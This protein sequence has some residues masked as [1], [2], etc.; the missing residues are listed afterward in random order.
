M[1]VHTK[2]SLRSGN[3]SLSAPIKY[4]CCIL[5]TRNK[6]TAD[7]LGQRAGRWDHRGAGS[8]PRFL[9]FFVLHGFAFF[10]FAG[11]GCFGFAWVCL[12]FAL[13]FS[14]LPLA[15]T[16]SACFCRSRSRFRILPLALIKADAS[17]THAASPS[18]L[19]A[20]VH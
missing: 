16:A 6:L 9:T 19:N 5:H 20:L 4:N 10:F 12:P 7:W 1:I 11:F 17:I 3:F 14:S 2:E 13:A 8:I 18:S 15:L